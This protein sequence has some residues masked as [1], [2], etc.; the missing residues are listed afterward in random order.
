MNTLIHKC[1]YNVNTLIHVSN[2]VIVSYHRIDEIYS[3]IIDL[4]PDTS[5]V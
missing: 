4:S 5:R 1:I 3:H 2:G